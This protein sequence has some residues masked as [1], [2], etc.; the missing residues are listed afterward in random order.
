[1][2]KIIALLC[3]LPALA[4]AQTSGEF[5]NATNSY[6][7]GTSQAGANNAGNSQG[8]SLTTNGGGHSQVV[9]TPS[10]QGN[11]FYGS[12]SPDGCTSS[13]GGGAAGWLVGFNFVM[14]H[15]AMFCYNLRTFERTMQWA[16]NLPPTPTVYTNSDGVSIVVP[17]RAEGLDT[18]F[19]LLC[20][21]GDRQR[22]VMEAHGRCGAVKDIPTF[23]HVGTWDSDARAFDRQY[24]T[25]HP[26]KH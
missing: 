5:S 19:D 15:D 9:A 3:L 17:S 22:A 26:Q 18:A 12:V 14:P 10:I 1:M 21:M 8:I 23:D 7:Q 25:D 4:L 24:A 13:E 20:L 16:V 2:K 6:G 11:G